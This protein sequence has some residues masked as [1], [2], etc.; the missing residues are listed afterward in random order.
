[1]RALSIPF[2]TFVLAG[3]YTY[4][5]LQEPSPAV[6]SR[7]SAEITPPGAMQLAPAMGVAAQ[8]I[9]GQVVAADP[10]LRDRLAN[11]LRAGDAGWLIMTAQDESEAA[12]GR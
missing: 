9:R 7:I 3:C 8:D 2:A 4:Q 12:L 11:A 6:G 1:M 5:P 10:D